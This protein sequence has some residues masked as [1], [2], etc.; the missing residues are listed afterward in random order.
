MVKPNRGIQVTLERFSAFIVETERLWKRFC[1]VS[2]LI[3]FLHSQEIWISSMFM[4]SWRVNAT[5]TFTVGE[6]TNLKELTDL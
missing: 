3:I 5:P 4:N 1:K 6:K 2:F